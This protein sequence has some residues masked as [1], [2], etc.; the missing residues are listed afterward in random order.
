M[1]INEL[2]PTD[3]DKEQNNQNHNKKNNQKSSNDFSSLIN[4]KDDEKPTH[5]T[6]ISKSPLSNDTITTI[7]Q[8]KSHKYNSDNENKD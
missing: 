6:Y 5:K 2:L 8:I 7:N 3:K 4:I 1:K